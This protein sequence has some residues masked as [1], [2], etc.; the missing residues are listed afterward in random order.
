MS[1]WDGVARLPLEFG[2]FHSPKTSPCDIFGYLLFLVR[3]TI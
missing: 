3:I 1:D 2:L